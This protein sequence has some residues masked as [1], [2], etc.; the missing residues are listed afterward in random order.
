MLFGMPIKES[1]EMLKQ[2]SANE[3]VDV[4]K[5]KSLVFFINF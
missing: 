2:I 1:L 3:A 5:D 4:F